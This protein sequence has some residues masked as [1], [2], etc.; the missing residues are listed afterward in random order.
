[1]I[2][3]TKILLPLVGALAFLTLI[4]EEVAA[5][6]YG[7]GPRPVRPR[8][9]YRHRFHGYVG[10]QLMGMGMVH[11]TF[12]EVGRLG[13][14]G[15]FGLFGGLRLGPFAAVEINWTFTG[16]DESWDENGA[17]VT[18]VDFLNL[19][20]L[21]ADF[22]LHI[23]TRGRFEPFVQAGLG[24]AFMGVTGDY[25]NDGYI[26]QS[27]GTWS[28]GGGGDFWFSPF[29][30]LGGRILYRGIYFT[31]SEYGT[32]KAE[33]NKLHGLSFEVSAAIHF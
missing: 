32:I 29:F 5:Q 15:G 7:Y 26:F 11:Q 21:T 8:W 3:R 33:T 13:P 30:T 2:R 19:Q 22:K 23:P 6:G 31:E 25:Y 28:L 20:T 1:M 14:G 10:G 27:G 9:G 24:F 16:H 18:A 4:P 17:T 12:E